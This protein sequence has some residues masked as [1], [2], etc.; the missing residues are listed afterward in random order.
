MG[1][2]VSEGWGGG[3]IQLTLTECLLGWP[4]HVGAHRDQDLPTP[5]PQWQ[6][7]VATIVL[8]LWWGPPEEA[9]EPV[10]VHWGSQAGEEGA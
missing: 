7:R 10:G 8:G 3:I 4:G 2:N 5:L 6:A 9:P 1:R